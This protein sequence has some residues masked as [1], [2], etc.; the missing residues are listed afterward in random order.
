[1]SVLV[2]SVN[3]PLSDTT[4]TGFGIILAFERSVGVSAVQ[5]IRTDNIIDATA[6][7][8]ILFFFIVIFS[9]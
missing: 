5:A 1:M 2:V 6:G 9:C 3:D 4:D 8:I 7:I